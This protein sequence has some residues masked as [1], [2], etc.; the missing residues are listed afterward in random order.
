MISWIL[1]IG[2]IIILISSVNLYMVGIGS[3]LMGFGANAA[4]TLHYTF[5]KELL[6]GSFRER[7]YIIIQISFSIGIAA[8]AFLSMLIP[9]WKIIA[10]FFILLPCLLIIPFSLWIV[11]ETPNFSLKAG[12]HELLASLNRIAK[13]NGNEPLM[14]EDLDFLPS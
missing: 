8:I 14:Y 11:E 12:K 1:N 4:T 6:V 5:L 10:G 3:F 2:G 9:N 7:S 13:F